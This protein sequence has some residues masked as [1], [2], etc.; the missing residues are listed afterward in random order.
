[1][2]CV[3][4]YRESKI[5]QIEGDGNRLS[6]SPVAHLCLHRTPLGLDYPTT[7]HALHSVE[8]LIRLVELLYLVAAS[9]A[10]AEDEDV[11]YCP[12]VSPLG[13]GL[14]ELQAQR[15][16]IELDDV[17]CWG[18]VVFLEEDVL[19]FLRVRAVGLGEDDDCSTD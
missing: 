8:Q 3:N 17:G 14:L 1:M 4:M 16:F 6:P 2:N 7:A 9:D 11:G 15:M 18:D 13:K 12:S 10:L 19:R 5:A